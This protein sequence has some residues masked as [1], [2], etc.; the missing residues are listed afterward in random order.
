M[1]YYIDNIFD[2]NMS[3]I[4]TNT[5]LERILFDSS[6]TEEKD[7]YLNKSNYY[8][9]NK[10]SKKTSLLNGKGNNILSGFG[11][12]GFDLTFAKDIKHKLSDVKGLREV[13][14]EVVNLIDMIKNPEIFNKVGVKLHKGILLAGKPGTG[15]TLL[16]KAIAGVCNV[17]FL[18][19]TGSDFDETFVGVGAK[20]V[21]ELFNKAR[22]NIPCIIFIDEI[23]SLLDKSRRSGGEHS[24]SRSTLNQFLSE[25]DGFKNNEGIYI[26]GATNNENSLDPAAVRPGRFDKTI[27]VGVPDIEGRKEIID[28]YLNKIKLKKDSLNSKVISLMTPG[29]TGAEIENLINLSIIS[30]VS[31]KKDIVSIE[32]IS[33]SRDRVL[34]GIARK[35]FT[36]PE[37]RRYKTA[38]HEAGHALVCYKNDLCK[39]NLHKLTVVPRGPAEGVVSFYAYLLY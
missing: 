21:K 8:D 34:M 32:E 6:I 11:L 25:I 19:V 31:K 15:K 5:R 14:E 3:I 26:I 10:S 37:K 17:N 9:K 13:K 38:L 28:Y 16:A 33:E 29:F 22:K 30:S 12:S 7:N 36:V 23:D 4:R 2:D 24:S 27:H 18:F 35:S 1:Y 20:R 39:K